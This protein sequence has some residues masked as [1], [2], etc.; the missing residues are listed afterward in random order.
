MVTVNDIG[1]AAYLK[2]IKGVNYAA[3][4]YKDT[5]HRKFVFEFEIDDEKFKELKTEYLNSDFRKFDGEI[6]DLKRILNQ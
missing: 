4:P 1:I 5:E 2:I 3:I 6:K